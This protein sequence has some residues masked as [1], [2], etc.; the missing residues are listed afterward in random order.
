MQSEPVSQ[1]QLK[2]E[3]VPELG[4][5]SKPRLRL[6]RPKPEP[7]VATGARAQC[8]LRWGPSY[9]LSA[10]VPTPQQQEAPGLPEPPLPKIGQYVD[11]WIGLWHWH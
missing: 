9:S 1:S 11:V 5:A 4:A 10:L 7:R 6:V 3:L 2:L 8:E